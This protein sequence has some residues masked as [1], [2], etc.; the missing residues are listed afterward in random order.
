MAMQTV[1]QFSCLLLFSA[2]ATA[3]QGGDAQC[4]QRSSRIVA[5]ESAVSALKSTENF[6][7]CEEE[8]NTLKQKIV[9]HSNLANLSYHLDT[10]PVLQRRSVR[11]NTAAP[12]HNRELLFLTTVILLT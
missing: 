7:L 3:A 12:P 1:F 5:I 11:I 8:L 9:D 6:D 4:Y 10:A 2:L